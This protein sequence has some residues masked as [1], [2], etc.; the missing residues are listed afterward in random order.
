LSAHEKTCTCAK[1]R[2]VRGGILLGWGVGYFAG[3]LVR[4][5]ERAVRRLKGKS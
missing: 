1:C 4:V 3:F 2:T 5:G